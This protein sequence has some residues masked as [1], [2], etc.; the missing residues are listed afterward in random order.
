MNVNVGF[1]MY[2]KLQKQQVIGILKGTNSKDPDVLFA[3]KEQA[4]AIANMLPGT[5]VMLFGAVLTITVI[6]AV[7]G[8]PLILIGW[9]AKKRRTENLATIE[10]AY[11]DYLLSIGNH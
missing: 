5:S 4:V 6:F 10:S 7:L 2:S 3:A 11:D 8:I 9:W 1:S